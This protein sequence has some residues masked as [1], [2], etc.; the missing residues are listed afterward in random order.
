MVQLIF[1]IGEFTFNTLPVEKRF[2]DIFNLI[3]RHAFKEKARFE[4]TRS[5]P[6][7]QQTQFTVLQNREHDSGHLLQ[8]FRF[9]PFPQAVIQEN[10]FVGVCL[11][12]S[13]KT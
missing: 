11:T 13:F 3:G 7:K 1:N 8:V 2:Y 12:I 9:F 6:L 4:F 5:K 10:H